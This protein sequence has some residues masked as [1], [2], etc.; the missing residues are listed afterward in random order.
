MRDS[1]YRTSFSKLNQKKICSSYLD[2]L[3]YRR[4]RRNYESN[5]D[6]L[7]FCWDDQDYWTE[8]AST[9]GSCDG[10]DSASTSSRQ[11][12]MTAKDK[13]VIT[14]RNKAHHH[15]S[16]KAVKYQEIKNDVGQ[17]EK[18]HDRVS[19]K[20][21]NPDAK[22][23]Q[24]PPKEP[25]T[26]SVAIQTANINAATNNCLHKSKS[27]KEPTNSTNSKEKK[28]KVVT[29]V[30]N[31]TFLHNRPL[32]VYGLGWKDNLCGPRRTF[33]ILAD[34]GVSKVKL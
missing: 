32:V 28:S 9:T 26:K 4:S 31:K 30:A 6:H 1:E 33:N 23:S 29:Q 19:N 15:Q 5:H 10:N 8:S 21:S 7:V 20:S 27:R 17:G 13:T 14:D 25:K 3:I 16:S 12:V 11:Q 24:S 34:N 18:R 22:K 2:N